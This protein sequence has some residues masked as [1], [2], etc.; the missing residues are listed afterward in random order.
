M[1]TSLWS[2]VLEVEPGQCWHWMGSLDRDGYG[3]FGSRGAHRV[4]YEQRVGAIPQGMQIDHLCRTRSCVNPLHL[5]VVTKE[6]NQRRGLAGGPDGLTTHC[7]AGHPYDNQNTYFYHGGDGLRRCCRACN[8]A[9][10]A[11]IQSRKRRPS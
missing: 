10:Q 8:R 11:R 4:V 7:P 2:R 5:E 6:E 9:I 3:R 1:V